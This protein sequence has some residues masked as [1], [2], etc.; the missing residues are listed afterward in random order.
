MTARTRLGVGILLLSAAIVAVSPSEGFAL[1][2]GGVGNAPMRDPGWPEGAAAIFNTSS[3][4]AWWEGP[5]FGGGQWHA[6]CRGD[7]KALSAVL[8]DFAKLDV[9]NKRVVLHD[10]AGRSFWLNPN[11]EPAKMDWVFMVWQPKNWEHL[12][13]L[14]ADIN[15]TGGQ[16]AESGPPSQIDVYTGG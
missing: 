14:P 10:G 13:K 7:A 3:R 5:P 8:A 6:E 15:P 12:R 16:D 2:I 1:L 11:N 4:I 9:K